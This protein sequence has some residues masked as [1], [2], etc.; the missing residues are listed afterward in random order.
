MPEPILAIAGLTVAMMAILGALYGGGQMWTQ[1]LTQ[2]GQLG[3]GKEELSF[4]KTEAKATREAGTMAM[5]QQQAMTERNWE[6]LGKEKKL[7]RT[8]KREERFESKQQSSEDRQ[9][10]MM[11]AMIQGM[12]QRDAGVSSA[13]RGMPSIP[14]YLR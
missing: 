5:K 13:S 10:A 12:T 6:R 9:L 2:K 4:K 8:E 11:L 14:S 7:D 1:Y 3:L